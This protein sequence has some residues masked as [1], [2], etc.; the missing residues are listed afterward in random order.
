MKLTP[1]LVLLGLLENSESALRLLEDILPGPVGEP[2]G[3]IEGEEMVRGIM[4]VGCVP[5]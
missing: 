4:T 1:I 5:F 2:G 3:V